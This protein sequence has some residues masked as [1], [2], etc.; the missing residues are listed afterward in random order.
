MRRIILGLVSILVLGGLVI[1][2]TQAW[3]SDTETSTGNRFQAGKIDLKIDHV[4]ASYNG[5]D[6][7]GECIPTGSQLLL[8]DD[9]EGPPTVTHTTGWDIFD[10]GTPGLG[11]RVEWVNATTPFGGFDRPSV[12]K[13]EF[14][15][16]GNLPNTSDIPDGWTAH[17]GT[18]YIELDS[19]WTGHS[20]VLNNEPALVRIY[21]DVTTIPGTKYELRYWHSYRPGRGLTDNTMNVKADGAILRTVTADGTGQNSTNWVEYVDVF[22]ATDN[23]T[24]IEF[25]GAEDDNSFGIFLDDISLF[26]L[27]CSTQIG[28]NQC[29]LWEEKD[30]TDGDI[31]WN[32]DDVKPGDYGRNVI[33]Y[34]VYDNNAWMCTLLGKEDAE[35]GVV[36]PET[37]AGDLGEPLGE[38][39]QFLSFFVWH[40]IDGNGLYEP[41]AG[42]TVIVNDT[43]DQISN[44]PIAEPPGSP[45]PASTPGYIGVAWCFGSQS[46]NPDGTFSCDGSGDHNI[47]QTDVANLVLEFYAEQSRN[48]PNFTCAALPTP[49]PV[50]TP[51]E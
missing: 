11:W 1:G 27:S 14:H 48:N 50:P 28:N 29:S 18:Q 22:T 5:R 21:Q 13:I 15:K 17:S 25:E 38:L 24:R 31:F 6:C 41:G 43:L 20:A 35:N 23:S 10:D 51:A 3:F 4:L 26:E 39:S 33:S 34:H 30:L 7:K 47:A 8:N 12:A 44:L 19:D 2:A 9:F 16:S 36:E 45:V 37:E 32:F 49:T 40:D 42:E 46:S